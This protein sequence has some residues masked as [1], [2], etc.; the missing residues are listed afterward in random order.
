MLSC[1]N[2]VCVSTPFKVPVVEPGSP[3]ESVDE[4]TTKL[5]KSRL[6]EICRKQRQQANLLA[7]AI[8]LLV[9]GSIRAFLRTYDCPLYYGKGAYI[10][11]VVGKLTLC[12]EE[13]TKLHVE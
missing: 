5:A 4:R 7:H 9:Y 3:M 6:C 2:P 1:E 8:F 11:C 12:P 13:S 10:R